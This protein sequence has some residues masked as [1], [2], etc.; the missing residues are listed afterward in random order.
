MQNSGF[1]STKLDF[2]ELLCDGLPWNHLTRDAVLSRFLLNTVLVIRV[3][4]NSRE[5]LNISTTVRFSPK[6]RRIQLTLCVRTVNFEHFNTATY[7]R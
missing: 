1:R 5:F 6:I 4:Q 3:V 7:S 2:E